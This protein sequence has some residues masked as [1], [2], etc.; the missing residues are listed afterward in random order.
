QTAQIEGLIRHFGREDPFLEDAYE[1]V[2]RAGARSQKMDCARVEDLRFLHTAVAIKYSNL[3]LITERFEG[4][5]ETIVKEPKYS[6]ERI[7]D[8]TLCVLG[9]MRGKTAARTMPFDHKNPCAHACGADED[10]LEEMSR[11]VVGEAVLQP[12]CRENPQG[13]PSRTQ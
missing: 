11:S 2:L 1:R 12:F 3:A 5:V 8:R 9:C 10:F 13:A 4:V 6:A 7:A